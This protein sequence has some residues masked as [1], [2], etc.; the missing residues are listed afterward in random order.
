MIAL[1][2]LGVLSLV[3]VIQGCTSPTAPPAAPGGGHTLVLSYSLFLNKVEPVL[4]RQGCDATGDCHGGGIRGA[5]QLSPPSAKD[6]QF[7]FNQVIL[8]VYPTDRDNSLILTK[9]LALSAGGVPHSYKPFA[10]VADTDYI[11]IRSWIDAGVLQ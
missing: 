2:L 3:S 5:L 6:P 8:E 7:D 1:A 10:S 4:V 9:P 11:A